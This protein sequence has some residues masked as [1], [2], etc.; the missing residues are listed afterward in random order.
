MGIMSGSCT[1]QIELHDGPLPPGFQ[2]D[3][4]AGTGGRCTFLGITRPE[5]HP[6]RGPLEA[7]H[8]EAHDAMA[9][10]A[11]EDLAVEASRRWPLRS[12]TLHHARGR[13]PIGE[14][15]VLIAVAAGHRDEAFAAC[16]WLIDSLKTSVPIWKQ[17]RWTEGSSWSTG[18]PLV[19][20]SA[21][22]SS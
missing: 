2:P 16:R 22:A 5:T 7:L 12:V 8:Y 10:Q 17:E 21:E 1:I 13:V 18:V 14:T 9:R 11:M 19:P 6:D 3:I 15:S 20:E 4:A